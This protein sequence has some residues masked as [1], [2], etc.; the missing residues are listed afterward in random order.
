[1]NKRIKFLALSSI[2]LLAA[3]C[4]QQHGWVVDGTIEGAS[5]RT[6]ALEQNVGGAWLLI[7]SLKTDSKGH[8]EYR[9]DS[10]AA[11]PDLYRLTYGGVPIY[12]PIDSLDHVTITTTAADFGGKYGMVGSE[13]ARRIA[14]ADSMIYA[15]A[16]EIGLD[17]A[18]S[19]STLKLNLYELFK[20]D[21]D[22]MT[23][24]YLIYRHFDGKP[25]FDVRNRDLDYKILGAVATKFIQVR[26]HDPRT[27]FLENLHR[28]ER[29]KRRPTTTRE[30]Q[31]PLAGLP[32]DIT[33]VDAKGQT[34]SLSQVIGKGHPTVLSFVALD[35]ESA[36]P[37][38][39][40]LNSLYEKYH[41]QGVE[42]FQVAVDD[43]ETDWLTTAKNLKWICVWGPAV[44]GQ[45][46]LLSYMVEGVPTTFIIDREG[47]V[48]Q[49]VDNYTTLDAVLSNY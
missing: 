19:D 15:R 26:P 46:P 49:R 41:G 20:G 12:F 32:A 5:D 3:A 45:N 44:T 14:R 33:S 4:S 22:V 24:Y 43:E 36:T 2:A 31:A 10:A 42:I 25:L 47:N 11:Y 35:H 40:A 28:Q 16:G 21:D 18:L 6:L 8:F 30:V 38:L 29:I 13:S 37:Y 39:M 1:M 48:A 34:R 9:A 17:K 7:D 27:S 23:P